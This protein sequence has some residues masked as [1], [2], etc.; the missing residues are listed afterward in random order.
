MHCFMLNPFTYTLY[1][2]MYQH[3]YLYMYSTFLLC[4]IH[5]QSIPCLHVDGGF[6]CPI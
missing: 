1:M 3:T 5:L 6:T 4:I 2:Y